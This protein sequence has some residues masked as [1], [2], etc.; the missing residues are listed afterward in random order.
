MEKLSEFILEYRHSHAMT[1]KDLAQLLGVTKVTISNI[2]NGKIRA[3]H[4][5]IKSIV[6]KLELDILEVVRLNENNKQI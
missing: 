2:E 1:Q 5:V 4:R 6:D 3:G